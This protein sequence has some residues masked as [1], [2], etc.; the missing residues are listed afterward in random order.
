[1]IT[2]HR[3]RA[4][5]Q[6]KIL[7]AALTMLTVVGALLA[8]PHAAVRA[9]ADEATV[10][11]TVTIALISISIDPTTFNY[12]ILVTNDEKRATAI[13][14]IDHIR[15]T[16]Q[17]NMAVD[18]D[19]RGADATAN[20]QTWTLSDTAIGEDRYM[21]EFSN[22]VANFTDPQR[23]STTDKTLATDIAVGGTHD[24]DLKIFTPSSVS[25]AGV[26]M[27]L[28]VVVTASQT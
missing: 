22:D 2:N 4:M 13:S 15:V 14:G 28:P 6:M 24:F 27:S 20:G 8:V 26:A 16:N 9:G 1:M 5:G 7:L 10:T 3:T 21:H 18:L 23:L 11:G 19:I 12:G 25:E 17:G